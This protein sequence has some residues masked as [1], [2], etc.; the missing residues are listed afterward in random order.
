MNG[1]GS[2][3]PARMASALAGLLTQLCMPTRSASYAALASANPRLPDSLHA[4]S[5]FGN[6]H[7][8][9][10]KFA[11]KC[12]IAA[13]DTELLG[14]PCSS[15]AAQSQR[16]LRNCLVQAACTTA[17]APHCM[18]QAL[19]EDSSLAIAI[20]TEETPHVQLDAYRDPLPEKIGQH[21]LIMAVRA[22]RRTTASRTTTP[23]FCRSQDQEELSY[24]CFDIF[25]LDFSS[26]G[27][28]GPLSHGR[29]RESPEPALLL[30]PITV[31][32]KCQLW[33]IKFDQEPK[34]EYRNQEYKAGPRCRDPSLR[35]GWPDR[36]CSPSPRP[37]LPP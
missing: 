9:T 18:R 11:Q 14:Q 21:P 37:S 12:G 36:T 5:V 13:K 17:I 30:S 7:R 32:G 28:Q 15:H 23:L 3:M 8:L 31:P 24:L 20:V 10:S 4:W 22:V 33:F 2:L 19:D 1:L 26:I 35:C 16:H 25:K 27:N 29:R 34:S 6:C